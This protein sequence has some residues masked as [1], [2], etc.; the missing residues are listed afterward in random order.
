MINFNNLSIVN[1]ALDLKMHIKKFCKTYI[2]KQ[3]FLT[4]NFKKIIRENLKSKCDV[5]Y[6]AEDDYWK[7]SC[8]AKISINYN[9]LIDAVLNNLSS[10]EIMENLH[11][12]RQ[13]YNFINLPFNIAVILKYPIKDRNSVKQVELFDKILHHKIIVNQNQENKLY[14]PAILMQYGNYWTYPYYF[15]EVNMIDP[16][17]ELDR[18]FKNELNNISDKLL[19]ML[20]SI[21]TIFMPLEI[22]VDY[23]NKLIEKRIS[24]TDLLL[25][26]VFDNQNIDE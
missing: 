25:T 1:N 4:E 2:D 17:K 18:L 5:I 16:S 23:N 6:I 21:F 9:M 8:K 26:G 12:F 7:K 13:Y 22:I 10:S 3:K 24:L 15:G 14:I 19:V 20:I 11:N